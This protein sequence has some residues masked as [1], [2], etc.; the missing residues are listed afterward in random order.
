MY[1]DAPGYYI[2]NGDH[3]YVCNETAIRMTIFTNDDSEYPVIINNT[4]IDISVAAKVKKI[5]IL[6][7][8]SQSCGN[9]STLTRFVLPFSGKFHIEMLNAK[10]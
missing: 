10:C 3:V 7:N 1:F 4:T 2:E 6:Y 8:V 5:L 9:Q